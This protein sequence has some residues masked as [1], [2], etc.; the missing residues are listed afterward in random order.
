MKK[1]FTLALGL[2]FAYSATAQQLV[3]PCSFDP[4]FKQQIQN[5]PG[6]IEHIKNLDNQIYQLVEK[7]KKDNSHKAGTILK[8]PIVFHIIHRGTA[9]GVAENISVAQVESAVRGMN[10]FYRNNKNWPNTPVNP[11]S[12]NS[13]DL[14]I[15]FC[16]AQRDPNGLP[17]NG[18]TRVDGAKYPFYQDQGWIN[19]GQANSNEVEIINDQGW[20]K[21]KYYNVFVVAEIN[22]QGGGGSGNVGNANFPPSGST[23]SA[24]NDRTVVIWKSTGYCGTGDP[25]PFKNTSLVAPYDNGTMNHEMGHAFSLY[26]TFHD[27]D[28]NDLSEQGGGTGQP[29]ASCNNANETAANCATSGDRCCDTQRHLGNL[30]TC[31]TGKTNECIGAP[32]DVFTANNCMNYTNCQPLLFTAGQRDRIKAAFSTNTVRINLTNSDGCNSVFAYDLGI[33]TISQPSGFYC[34][35]NVSG[36]IGVKN[37]GANTITSATFDILVDNVSVTTYLDRN[38]GSKL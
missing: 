28:P 26:H 37:Y 2:I 18:I 1:I 7:A 33:N 36:K 35:V 22:N 17:T 8:I 9:E 20:N 5:E 34:D 3:E 24:T 14:E 6:F 12:P 27:K 10:V 11:F 29:V 13:V 19:Q 15:E 16:L 25:C 38:P 31:P 32:Y 30:G 21:N 4:I 23:P